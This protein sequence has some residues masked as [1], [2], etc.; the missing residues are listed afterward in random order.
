LWEGLDIRPYWESVKKKYQ[1][2]CSR[3]NKVT[4]IK[5]EIQEIKK[6]PGKLVYQCNKSQ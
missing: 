3:C 5:D 6:E 1:D 2:G 4:A